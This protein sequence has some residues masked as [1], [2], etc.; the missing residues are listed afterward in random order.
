MKQGPIRTKQKFRIL[1]GG[2]SKSFFNQKARLTLKPFFNIFFLYFFF[3]CLL[4]ITLNNYIY[5]T[6]KKKHFNKTLTE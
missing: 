4:I 2:V 1:E 3:I 5:K 6:Q